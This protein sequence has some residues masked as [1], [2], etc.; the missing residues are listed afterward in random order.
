MYVLDG[1]FCRLPCADAEETGTKSAS[2]RAAIAAATNQSLP[3]RP[4]PC[5]TIPPPT[6]TRPRLD[7]ALHRFG[8]RRCPNE[9][10]RT[11]LTSIHPCGL[12][13]DRTTLVQMAG[14]HAR[15]LTAASGMGTTR[16]H[17]RPC[18]RLSPPVQAHLTLSSGPPDRPARS[19]TKWPRPTDAGSVD[20]H[21]LSGFASMWLGRSNELTHA[22]PSVSTPSPRV[23]R[24]NHR[25]GFT[26][27]PMVLLGSDRHTAE[28]AP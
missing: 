19:I 26:A 16:R 10:E 17:G 25:A 28:P 22:D 6:A 11:S 3:N 7:V 9:P 2:T 14:P 15:A 23:A 21:H 4:L 1:G 5:T 13:A 8:Y 18:W 12:T 24:P 27:G 20:L